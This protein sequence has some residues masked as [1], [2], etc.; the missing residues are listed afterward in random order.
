MNRGRC[1]IASNYYS[2]NYSRNPLKR[3]SY[4][5][6]IAC[7]CFTFQLILLVSPVVFAQTTLYNGITL[8]STWPP[9]QSPSQAYQI[10]SYIT[11]PPSVI[12]IDLGRQLFVDDFLVQQTSLTRLAHRPV[13]YGNNPVLSPG[14]PDLKGWAFPFSDGVCYDPADHL[15]KMWYFG[16]YGNMVSY[17]Y[18]SDGKNWTKPLLNVVVPNTN[19]VIQVGGGRDS[20]TVWMDLEDPNPARKFKAFVLRYPPIIDI[21]FS[22]DGIHWSAPQPQTINSVSDRTTVFWNPFRKVWVDSVRSSTTLPA[23]GSVA[24]HYSRVRFYSESPDLINWTPANPLNSFWTGP[25][26]NDPPYAGPGGA[27]PELYNLDAVA[28]ESILV[29]LFSWYNP[30]PAYSSSYGPGPNLVELGVGFSRDGFNWVRPTRGGG[31]NAFIPASNTAGTWNGYNTQ[32]AGGGFLVVGDELWFYF[33]GRDQPKPAIGVASTGLATLRRDGFYSMNAGA[34]EGLLTTRP[35]RFSGKYLFVNVNNPGGS[36]QVEVLDS[37]GAVIAPFAKQNSVPVS[38]NRTLQQITWNGVA[39]LSS[40]AGKP[41][42]FRFYLTNG[43]L[44][45]FWVAQ[46]LR[47]ASNGYVA[48][49]GPGFTGN[50]DTIGSGGSGPPP[51]PPPPTP[52]S[53]SVTPSSLSFTATAG[54]SNPA[55]QPASVSNSGGGTLTWTASANQPWITFSPASGTGAQTISVGTTIGGL[56]AG[57]YSGAMT[58]SAPG[59][60]P[61]TQTVNV[62]L[63]ITATPPPPPP[64][65]SGTVGYWT[66]DTASVTGGQ[67]LDSSGKNLNGKLFGSVTSITGVINQALGFDGRSNYIQFPSDTL[68]DLTHDVSLA[69]WINTLNSSR[70]EAV[71]S[72]YSAAAMESGYVLRSTAAGHVDLRIGG[73]NWSGGYPTTLADTGKV[74]NDGHWHHVAVVIALGRGVRFYIDG[75]LSSAPAVNAVA[76]AG[77]SNLQIAATHPYYGNLLTGSL[78][79]VRIYNRALSA[80]EIGALAAH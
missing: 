45:S 18:S 24:N 38:V 22:A 55:A 62:S 30:G 27:L 42:Q 73:N 8:P 6:R 50:R 54:G 52:P 74:I 35:V 43:E 66:L 7:R 58:V 79:D 32:S 17:A 15:F 63:S 3:L 56:A 23:V 25:D 9:Q 12:P 33:S 14:G 10:P 13:M 65:G 51:P 75:A 80:S 34:T 64:S 76:Q 67:V 16:S 19:T 57:T 68:T 39:D 40:V 37:S 69:L 5:F 60:T 70:T 29:G 72:R 1:S 77:G 21:Y 46:D 26:A 49:G 2:R 44:Y 4:V 20:V 36:L 71:L 47:G 61:S 53:L 11:S 41:V 31:V 28:Y 48:A 78:D 59:A